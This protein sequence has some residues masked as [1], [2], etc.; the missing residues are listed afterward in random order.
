MED[1]D[2]GQGGVR[3][4]PVTEYQL[5]DAFLDWFGLPPYEQAPVAL[6]GY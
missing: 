1:K 2:L 6:S 4:A 5:A 3:T